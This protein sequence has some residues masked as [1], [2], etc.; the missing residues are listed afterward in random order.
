MKALVACSSDRNG[1]PACHSTRRSQ[2]HLY[3][4]RPSHGPQPPLLTFP[5]KQG[6][7]YISR[8][9]LSLSMSPKE[10]AQMCQERVKC[11]IQSFE[12][13]LKYSALPLVQ[14]DI[15]CANSARSPQRRLPHKI[16]VRRKV[17][18]FLFPA[19]NSA[20]SLT[21]LWGT[22]L[23]GTCRNH[24]LTRCLSLPK[25]FVGIT[26]DCLTVTEECR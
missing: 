1:R 12:P 13:L 9:L 24:S 2:R 11:L 25:M 16:S 5:R 4:Q 19:P 3:L 22:F 10:K 20:L 21:G 18:F 8:T 26:S 6:P 17:F 23:R 7:G 14:K 15:A